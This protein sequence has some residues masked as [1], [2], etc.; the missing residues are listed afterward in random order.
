[1]LSDLV[2]TPYTREHGFGD[3]DR[4]RLARE[5]GFLAEALEL[6]GKPSPDSVFTSAFLPDAAK[7]QVQ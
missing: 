2:V 7:R 5:I 6:P 3:V 4:A 1:V